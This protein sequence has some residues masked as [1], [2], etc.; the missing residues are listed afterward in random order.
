MT[1][2]VDKWGCFQ[3]LLVAVPVV[4]CCGNIPV[5]GDVIQ[6]IRLGCQ[7]KVNEVYSD[8]V[9]VSEG[10]LAIA[11][12]RLVRRA[13]EAPSRYLVSGPI[14][15]RSDADVSESYAEFCRRVRAVVE[16]EAPAVTVRTDYMR[17]AKSIGE[18]VTRAPCFIAW[19]DAHDGE[20]ARVLTVDSAGSLPRELEKQVLE[21]LEHAQ[22]EIGARKLGKR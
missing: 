20:E 14:R 17:S 2:E 5:A 15:I 7:H 3:R 12:V 8:R 18:G 9:D 21:V 22:R 1:S 19:F 11:S 16:K 6:C 10:K 4:Y 13:E